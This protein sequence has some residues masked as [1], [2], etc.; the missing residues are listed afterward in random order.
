[1]TPFLDSLMDQSLTCTNAF[2]NGTKSIEGIP[3]ILSGLPSLMED[4]FINSGYA[5][6]DQTSFAMLLGAEG[7]QT[8]FFHG[9]INGTMNFDSWAALAGYQN[10]FGKNEYNNNDDFDGFWGIWDEPFCNTR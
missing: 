5:F 9:G 4:P 3:A 6:N 7:Y 1:M 8:S 10:Y 2:S